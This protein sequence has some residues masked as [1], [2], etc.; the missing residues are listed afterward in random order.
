[1]DIPNNQGEKVVPLTTAVSNDQSIM[2]NRLHDV[3][4]VSTRDRNIRTV[5][6]ETSV[7]DSR[8]GN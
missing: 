4:I 6:T 3:T 7:G 5:T 8:Y 1:M 2:I